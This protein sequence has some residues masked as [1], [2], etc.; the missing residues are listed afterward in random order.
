MTRSIAL[1]ALLA[2]VCAAATAAQAQSAPPASGAPPAPNAAGGAPTPTS[3]QVGEIVVTAERRSERLEDVP[4][5][6]SV[7]SSDALAKSNYTEITNLQFVV[8]GLQYNPNVGGGFQVRGV[9]TQS[10]NLTTEQ[11]VGIVIDDVVQ[12]VPQLTFAPP[13]YDAL[14]DIDQ[15]EVLKGPQGTLFG[16][17]SSVGVLQVITKRPELGVYSGDADVS[18]GTHGEYKGQINLN[19]PVG[20]TVALRLSGFELHHDGFIKNLYNGQELGGY[21]EYG[22][23]GKL[24]WKPTSDLTV[25]LIGERIHTS[26]PGNGAWTLRS[27]GS[28]FNTFSACATDAPYGIVPGPNNTSVALDAPTPAS[29]DTADGSLH[30]EYQIGRNTLTSITAYMHVNQY[31]NVDVDNSPRPIL[32]ADTSVTDSRQFTQ[33]L[34]FSSPADQLIE[35]TVGAFFMKL[36]S[37]FTN[38]LAGTFD[39][40][41]DN[42]T[43]LLSN[44]FAGTVSGGL[45]VLDTSTTSYAV[46]GQATI[47]ATSRLQLIGGLRFSHDD[48]SAGVY[49]APLPNVCEFD[50]AFDGVCHSVSLPST[51]ETEETSASNVS[52]KGTLKYVFSDQVNAYVTYATGYKAP[53]ISYAALTPLSTV[54][55]ETSRAVEVGLKSELLDRTLV[56]NVDAFYEKYTNFQADTFVLNEANPS[57]SNF[58]LANAGGLES[59][60]FEG[61]ATWRATQELTL[62]GSIT[63]AP[64]KF[65]NFVIQCQSDFTNP[66]TGPCYTVAGNSVFNAA[67][68]PLPESPTTSYTLGADWRHPVG[69]YLVD[70]SGTW[71]WRSS[72]YSLVADTDTI[73]K[74]YGLLGAN[75]AFGPASG[76]WQVAIFARNILDQKFVAGIFQTFLDNGGA[77]AI[78]VPTIGYSNI[79]SIEAMRTV[80]MKISTRW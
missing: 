66:A 14:S 50:Y 17:N 21:D 37:H 45:T 33:E 59:R 23:R 60:G 80:G 11:D 40:E 52:G 56:L 67:G 31:E 6:V 25:Y 15:I 51:P 41:P 61:D 10:I 58:E 38:E 44:G 46:Y 26:D 70:L 12:S 68:Y 39:F 71:N 30:I 43:T 76:R 62:S 3:S 55:P 42:S 47:H 16:K 49:V 65:T 79:P 24:L 5:A 78:A 75:V 9:G 8:P 4:V 22:F 48:V 32:D 69:A 13:S 57:A 2:G 73:Q 72:T 54:Q 35:Y 29:T 28:G 7:V 18:A 20:D 63:Y 1:G 34:R 36:D 77:T 74:G 64:T 27:C 53:A 19:I